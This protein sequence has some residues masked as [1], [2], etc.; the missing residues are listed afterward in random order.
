MSEA[1]RIRRMAG[2]D[3]ALVFWLCVL[4]VAAWFGWL[5]DSK[6][7]YEMAYDDVIYEDK[8]HD[9]DFITAPLGRKNCRYEKKVLIVYYSIGV[10]GNPII[11]RDHGENWYVN[12]GGPTDGMS[13]YISWVR[14]SD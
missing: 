1:E 7:R 14:Y 10:N 12:K 5:D 4:V 3:S 11:S 2:D 6:L 13:V 8:P 9:C